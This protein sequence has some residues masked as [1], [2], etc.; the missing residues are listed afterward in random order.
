MCRTPVGTKLVVQH[1]ERDVT[2]DA[3]ARLERRGRPW[4]KSSGAITAR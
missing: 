2:A 1:G 3:R 4:S